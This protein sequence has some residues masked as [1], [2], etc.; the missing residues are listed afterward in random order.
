MNILNI[1]KRLCCCICSNDYEEDLDSNM[2]I[3]PINPNN[4]EAHEVYPY[5]KSFVY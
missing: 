5:K 1:L 4:F 2:T 3:N